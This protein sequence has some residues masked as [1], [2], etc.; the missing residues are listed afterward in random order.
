[1]VVGGVGVS[2]VATRGAV[3]LRVR[4]SRV[5]LSNAML[6]M[7]Y[8][9]GRPSDVPGRLII[10]LITRATMLIATRA[11]TRKTTYIERG[12]DARLSRSVCK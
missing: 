12:M 1:M 4:F 5:L 11:A 10:Y 9:K 2:V 8:A 6:L 3:V 7:S